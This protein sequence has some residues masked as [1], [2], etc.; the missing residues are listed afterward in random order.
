MNINQ[1]YKFASIPTEHMRRTNF[2]KSGGVKTSFDVGQLVPIKWYPVLPGD[3]WKIK[4]SKVLRMPALITP[5]MS[6]LFLDVDWFFVPYRLIWSHWK[7]LMGENT[8]S[9][10]IPQNQ[11]SCP[12]L[13]SPETTGW[14]V[15]SLADY[16]G[17]PTGVPGL[18]VNALPFRAYALVV[19]EF[20]RNQNLQ[21][22]VNIP[23]DDTTV[24]GSNGT[25][26]ITDLVKGGAPFIACKLH[27]QFTS[28]LPGP[29]KGSASE[30]SLTGSDNFPVYAFEDVHDY[31][32]LP[33]RPNA[34]STYQ[35]LSYPLALYRNG[36]G[37]T[38][39]D[40][41][42]LTYGSSNPGQVSLSVG[43]GQYNTFS[44]ANLWA[45]NPQISITINELRLAFQVQR[46]LERDARSGTRYI[47]TIFA[48]FGIRSPDARLQRPEF[49]GGSRIPLRIAQVLQ[50]SET[51][52]TP[53]GTPTGV[54]LTTDTHYDFEKSFTEH[55]VLICVATCRYHHDYQNAL[56]PEWLRKTRYDWFWPAL[57]HIGEIGVPNSA[58]YA[59]GSSVVN[60]DGNP[61]DDEIFGYQES[62]YDYK[63]EPN[64]VT[65]QMRSSYAQSLDVWHL[66]DDYNSLPSLSADWI[67]E[68]KSN[69]DRVL[70]VT[71]AVTNQIFGDFWFDAKAT[72]TMPYYGVPGLMD[73]F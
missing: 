71:S 12:Q 60:A 69:V 10:W 15:G 59:Q 56:H 3:T 51:G 25:N 5:I 43:V 11:Y 68:D 57:S 8:D 32:D 28:C 66:A 22:P 29:Q 21:D 35:D 38:A 48:H 31:D 40:K 70:S 72:R 9:A 2:D 46:L 27:D 58:I 42:S 62:W 67:K 73:H 6:N 47:E 53:Q 30:V 26:Y 50:Q 61:V 52:T 49:L 7:N 44:P 41:S 54:S 34:S 65:G 55:G 17:I 16:F 64:I 20:W 37:S 33:K 39:T 23:V 1:E 18:S 36:S 4:S 14:N 63:F 13:T 24:T 19:N 45:V